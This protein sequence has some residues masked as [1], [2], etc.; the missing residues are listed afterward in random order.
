MNTLVLVGGTGGNML[1]YTSIDTVLLVDTL[2][3]V[4]FIKL[5]LNG[6]FLYTH[7]CT[8]SSNAIGNAM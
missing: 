8:S 2:R 3:N 5:I 1:I 4:N 7:S 6:F